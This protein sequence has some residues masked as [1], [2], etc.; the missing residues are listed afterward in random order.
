MSKKIFRKRKIIVEKINS[1]KRKKITS[2]HSC[3]GIPNGQINSFINPI[4]SHRFTVNLENDFLNTFIEPDRISSY[5]IIHS[6]EGI[7]DT[8]MVETI[9]N[10]GEWIDE[11]KSMKIA[12]IFIYDFSGNEIRFFDFDIEF[13]SQTISGSYNSQ[14]VL[15]PSITY[16]II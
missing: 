5:E 13:M 11:F 8:L 7:L 4:L 12:R 14:K 3:L 16:K 10:V 6:R 2:P 1:T 15:T 9:L